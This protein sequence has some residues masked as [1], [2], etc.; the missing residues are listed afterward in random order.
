[1]KYFLCAE[2]GEEFYIKAK[3]L[4]QATEDA[5][6]WGAYVIRQLTAKEVKGIEQKK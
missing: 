5:S 2:H 4:K 6:M 3:D 1:M